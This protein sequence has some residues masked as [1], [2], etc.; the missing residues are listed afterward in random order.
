MESKKAIQKLEKELCEK[1]LAKPLKVEKAWE[2]QTLMKS[3]GIYPKGDIAK[4][5]KEVAGVSVYEIKLYQFLVD[6]KNQEM[7]DDYRSGNSSLEASYRKSVKGQMRLCDTCGKNVDL[8]MFRPFRKIC[9]PCENGKKIDSEVTEAIKSFQGKPPEKVTKSQKM[10]RV[11][12]DIE[13]RL[14]KCI[15][16]FSEEFKKINLMKRDKAYMHLLKIYFNF[17]NAISKFGGNNNE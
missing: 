5:V 8:S 4:R 9:S 17:G 6:S 12:G 13:Y 3:Q 16:E 1:S 7:I 15:D 14:D 2:L 10:D 11:I